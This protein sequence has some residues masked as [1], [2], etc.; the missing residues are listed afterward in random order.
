M[1]KDAINIDEFNICDD[2]Q[3]K[4]SEV[5]IRHKSILDVITKLEEYNSR[6]NRAIVK[7]VTSCGCLS[8]SA[9]KQSYNKET[10]EEVRDHMSDHLEGNLCEV[11]EEMIEEE[12]GAYLFYLAALCN[13]ID[14]NLTDVLLREYSNL[15][16]LGIYSIK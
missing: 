1:V 14:V 2:F 10:L 7:S 4:V 13:T 8:I 5:L 15:K 9:T 16:T 3:K 6:I 11:C 12:I